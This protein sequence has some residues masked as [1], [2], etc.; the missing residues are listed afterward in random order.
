M[1]DCEIEYVA[2]GDSYASGEG[3]RG[4]DGNYIAGTDDTGPDLFNTCHRSDLAYGKLLRHPTSASNRVQLKA[5]LACSGAKVVNLVSGG[6][7]PQR[8]L[9]EPTQLDNRRIA[10][11]T[12]ESD[13]RS[14]SACGPA[15]REPGEKDFTWGQ[16]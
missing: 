5:L 12:S 2:L 7:S 9:S 13:E 3:V 4:Q 10:L 1:P 8:A 11:G 15:R 16:G 6:Q 14:R